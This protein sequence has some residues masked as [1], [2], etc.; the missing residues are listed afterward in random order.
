[1]KNEYYKESDP[2]YVA[3]LGEMLR[4]A[5]LYVA[6]SRDG[7]ATKLGM[8]ERSYRRMESGERPIPPGLLDT[9]DAVLDEFDSAV[10]MVIERASRSGDLV[11][12]VRDDPE[13]EWHRAVVGRAAIESRRI[14]PTL[15]TSTQREE[16]HRGARH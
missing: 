10:E 6:L 13:G 11:I 2:G 15:L 9:M 3:G 14:M 5:R 8:A 4:S 12:E 1:M 7:F 16:R